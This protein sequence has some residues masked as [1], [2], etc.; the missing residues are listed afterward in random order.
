[1]TIGAAEPRR[2]RG[3]LLVYVAA[4]VLS[5]PVLEMLISGPNARDFAH[6][7][8]DDG[9]V[10]RLGAM[11]FDLSAFGPVLW[12]AHLM[13]GNTYIGQFNGTP[14]ALDSVL[15]LLTTPFAGY[16]ACVALMAL[17]A[18]LSMHVFLEDSVC[19]PRAAAF[20]GGLI[21]V[22]G[23]RHYAFG[24]S[25][26]L[27]PLL[28][29][30]SDRVETWGGRRRRRVVP[31]ALVAAFMLY[32]FAAQPAVIAGGLQLF[33]CLLVAETAAERRSRVATW[34]GAWTLGLA[35]YGPV[36]ATQLR[37]LP[38]SVR[39]VRVVASDLPGMLSA[40]T[41]VAGE[42]AE[43]LLSRPAAIGAGLRL[44]EA[45]DGIW[46]VGFAAIGL[47]A[48]SFATPRKTR[49]E[50]ALAWLLVG[51][52]VLDLLSILIA[53]A[54]QRLGALQSFSIDRVRTFLPFALAANAAVAVALLFRPGNAGALKR[55]PPRTVAAFLLVLS[56]ASGALCARFLVYI[57][58]R[59]A[60]GHPTEPEAVLAW[61]AICVYFAFA[62][63][64]AVILLR[65]LRLRDPSGRRWFER[66]SGPRLVILLLGLLALER[67]IYTRIERRIEQRTLG[68]FSASLEA[69][70]AIRFLKSR[71]PGEDGRTLTLA[72]RSHLNPRLHP[73]RM[74]YHGLYAADGYQ[75]VYPLRYHQVFALLI[76]PHLARDAFHRRYFMEWGQRAY[77][78]GPEFRS[79]LASLMG[80]RWLYARN[81]P[82]DRPGW[83][84]AFQEGD[85]RVYENT[86]AFPRA[87]LVSAV[88]TFPDRPALLDAMSTA[89]TE[90]L[91]SS[92]FLEGP[93][94]PISAARGAAGNATLV[95][96]TPDRVVARVQTEAPS[97]LVLT[98]NY[99]PG[100][101]ASIGGR[102]LEILPAYNCFRA[103]VV[104][105]GNSEVIFS[106]EPTFTYVGT[107]VAAAAVLVLLVLAVTGRSRAVGPS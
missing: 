98:D 87:F 55:S 74:M 26:V 100:W 61:G 106:Y 47:L 69:T 21:Y 37:L 23:F 107:A 101:K 8:F 89:S 32:D 20:A 29:W 90:E 58:R 9:A 43:V 45:A 88:T 62:S 99:A 48:M 34:A 72:D 71:P 33:Y 42:Y 73:N 80:V 79:T 81:V 39:T 96:D 59:E 75:D 76:W 18:G 28:L 13:A 44:H 5:F 22:L 11:R 97:L 91:R 95:S 92:V 19:L 38:E 50:R 35:L 78:F 64:A 41:R 65:S 24:F 1:M 86:E 104:P 7:V 52:P 85:E 40:A 57:L 82:F 54:L 70:P 2:W 30:M 83:R 66:I 60:A 31:L 49:R 27:L 10:S 25:A 56:L 84:L 15:A 16:A 6:D 77:L 103:V 17:A 93:A 14:I 46:Y 105:A 3:V 51:I 36:L 12:N 102:S 53:P 63:V 94:P 67:L 68:S 4:T